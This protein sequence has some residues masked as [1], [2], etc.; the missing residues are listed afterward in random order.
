MF[1]LTC[2]RLHPSVTLGSQTV[3][4]RIIF[5]LSHTTTTCLHRKTNI[6]DLFAAGMKILLGR[7]VNLMFSTEA[8]RRVA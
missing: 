4:D 8:S 7:N 3:P 5:C 6:S 1:I 2:V